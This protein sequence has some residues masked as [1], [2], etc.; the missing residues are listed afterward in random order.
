MG[1]AKRK[2]DL[3]IISKRERFMRLLRKIGKYGEREIVQFARNRFTP[4]RTRQAPLVALG[5]LVPSK[6]L[7][8]DENSGGTA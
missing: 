3:G 2:K 6:R 8:G 4:Q 7:Y 5:I 1:Q